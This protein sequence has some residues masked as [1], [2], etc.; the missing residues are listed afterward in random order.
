MPP[1]P[2]RWSRLADGADTAMEKASVG[3]ALIRVHGT[4]ATEQQPAGGAALQC[5]TALSNSRLS[6][7]RLALVGARQRWK[8][9]D[10][11]AFALVGARQRSWAM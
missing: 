6:D 10:L 3:G 11:A 1:S 5:L 4:C 7:M 2:C 8:S 9:G